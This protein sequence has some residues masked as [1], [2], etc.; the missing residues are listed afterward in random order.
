[1]KNNAKRKT[2]TEEAEAMRWYAREQLDAL[3][4][5][6][7]YG[8]MALVVQLLRSVKERCAQEAQEPGPPDASIC[9]DD[10]RQV[11]PGE[12]DGASFL[13]KSTELC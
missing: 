5:L 9:P 13:D 8:T 10:T 3:P 12:Q 7:I 6:A 4:G 11:E 2:S 1:M